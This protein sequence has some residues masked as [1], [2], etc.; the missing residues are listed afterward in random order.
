LQTKDR[1]F[2]YLIEFDSSLNIPDTWVSDKELACFNQ[3]RE[4][5]I[6]PNRPIALK[7]ITNQTVSTIKNNKKS[8]ATT[9]FC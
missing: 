8:S 1:G 9:K 7:S 5:I 2:D 6:Q 4:D 3:I